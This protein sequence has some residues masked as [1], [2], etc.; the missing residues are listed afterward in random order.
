[1]NNR[2]VDRRGQQQQH[3]TV[4][5]KVH[6]ARLKPALGVKKSKQETESCRNVAQADQPLVKDSCCE[7]LYFDLFSQ[8]FGNSVVVLHKL[9]PSP[10]CMG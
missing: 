3:R 5:E 2:R 9:G 8:K 7:F 1:M 6:R 10:H 4:N